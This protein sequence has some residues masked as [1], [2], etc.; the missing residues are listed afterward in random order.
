M[1]E[2]LQRDPGAPAAERWAADLATWA[3]PRD[4]LAAAPESPWHFPVG[5]FA[6]RADSARSERTP[7]NQRALEALP[8]GGSV[9]DVGCGG[10]AASLPLVPPAAL[11]IGVDGST[12]MLVAF[13]QRARALPARVQAVHGRWPD[14]ATRTPE[15]D[16]VVCHHVAYNAPDLPRF[17]AALTAHARRRVVLE[18][19]REHPQSDL[20][21]LWLRFHGVVRPTRPTSDD[22]EAVLR[23]AGLDVRRQDWDTR[24]P[25]G[26]ESRGALIAHVRRMLCLSAERDPEI[27]EAVSERIVQRDGRFG[28]PDRG[29]TT[30]WWAGRASP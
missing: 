30:L 22:A 29:V 3:I 11:L 2:P 9:L 8:A 12:D 10:G 6:S 1:S 14:A 21:P 23:E 19:T 17:A 15:A 18:L 16:V 25:G 26:Y 13:E 27:E 5:L 20:N 24:R 4:I 28:L 7:S